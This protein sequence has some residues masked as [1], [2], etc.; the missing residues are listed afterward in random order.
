MGGCGFPSSSVF[1]YVPF[2]SLLF[3][4]KH[5]YGKHFSK[6]ITQKDSIIL[7]NL[8]VKPY[9]FETIKRKQTF[10]GSFVLNFKSVIGRNVFE[11]QY[12]KERKLSVFLWTNVSEA[13]AL[14]YQHK[15]LSFYLA[16][17][18]SLFNAFSLYFFSFWPEKI[19]LSKTA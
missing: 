5:L 11:V 12:L 1:F 6:L 4:K 7:A 18:F 16:V 14:G 8:Q 17:F 10:I 19:F 9:N 3:L 15:W 13:S 2:F